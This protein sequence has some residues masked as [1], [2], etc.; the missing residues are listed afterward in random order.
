ME[1]E[2]INQTDPDC[3]WRTKEIQEYV[4]GKG[5]QKATIYQLWSPVRAMVLYLKL[6][7]P[8]RTY[9]VRMLDSGEADTFRYDNGQW[10]ENAAHS[11]ALG[12]Y[13][14]TLRK[15]RVSAHL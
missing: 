5:K 14:T 15:G 7:L 12:K 6:Q 1:P 10:L 9:Q 3:V 2:L 13:Q 4:R 8:L 11:F